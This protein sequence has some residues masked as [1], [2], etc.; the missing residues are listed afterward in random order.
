MHLY[1][2]LQI[3]IFLFVSVERN[4]WGVFENSFVMRDGVRVLLR[5]FKERNLTYFYKLSPTLFSGEDILNLAILLLKMFYK[6]TNKHGI[7][8]LIIIYI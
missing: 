5:A 4:L 2:V 1:V 6:P 7:F 3:Q 8:I